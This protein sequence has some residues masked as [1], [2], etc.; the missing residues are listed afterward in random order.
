[1]MRLGAWTGF[2]LLFVPVLTDTDSIRAEPATSVV[3]CPAED[4]PVSNLSV[5]F[6][7]ADGSR[8]VIALVPAQRPLASRCRA[9]AVAAPPGRPLWLGAVSTRELARSKSI[10]L[11]RK[12]DDQRVTGLEIDS[13]AVRPVSERPLI[14]RTELLPPRSVRSFGSQER[15]TVSEEDSAIALTCRA[16]DEVAGAAIELDGALHPRLKLS[17]ELE[18][19]G[20]PG[21][22]TRIKT[23]TSDI[24]FAPQHDRQVAR[25]PIESAPGPL[26][27]VVTCPPTDGRLRLLRASVRSAGG[28]LPDRLATWVWRPESW[29][30]DRQDLIAWAR[31]QSIAT[32]FIT[33]AID[34]DRVTDPKGLADF[35]AQARKADIAVVAVEGDPAMIWGGEGRQQALA[36]ARALAA[37]QAETPA[38]RLSGVQYDIEPYNIS[39][40]APDREGAWRSWAEALR[41]L[42][43]ELG[44]RIDAVVPFWIV[45][46][47][48]GQ[49]ALTAASPALRQLTIMAYRTE[50]AAIVAAAAPVLTWATDHDIPVIVA[51][52]SGA[53]AHERRDVF[54][55]ADAGELQI[56]NFGEIAAA[57]LLDR[58]IP[59]LNAM[60]YRYGHSVESDASRITFAG[61]PARLVSA[62]RTVAADLAAWP[63]A[64]GIAIH[65][66]AARN[67]SVGLKVIRPKTNKSLH[68]AGH[69]PCH[70][71]TDWLSKPSLAH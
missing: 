64:R 29:R 52:E 69:Q 46:G 55:P 42:S 38:A 31:D 53:L 24:P 5:D 21:F 12:A 2:A 13:A 58:P 6:T 30:S 60:A 36:R 45:E 15:I 43:N 28:G 68:D 59:P 40:F 9:E 16:G 1:M 49:D 61:Q 34:G 70:G 63:A 17:L 56:V 57:I 33:V 39:G 10:T 11:V 71:A 3:L 14:P 67:L 4:A 37:Y 66:L 25:L 23:A 32:L 8:N 50:P 51:L 7:L 54:Q 62:V 47:S 41:T 19:A 18:A 65:G 27:I 48:G 22:R 35:V 44:E 26:S 20:D